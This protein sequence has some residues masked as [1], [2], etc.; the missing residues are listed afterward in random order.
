MKGF[1]QGA[2]C[3]AALLLCA[4][5]LAAQ[6]ADEGGLRLFKPPTVHVSP[7]ELDFIQRQLQSS[8]LYRDLVPR[9][10]SAADSRTTIVPQAITPESSGSDGALSVE[11]ALAAIARLRAQSSLAHLQAKVAQQN[12]AAESTTTDL[13]S[14]TV[15]AP[16]SPGFDGEAMRDLWANTEPQGPALQIIA[17][18]GDPPY[19]PVPEAQASDYAAAAELWAWAGVQG[20]AADSTAPN[21]SVSDAGALALLTLLQAGDYLAQFGEPYAANLPTNRPLAPLQHGQW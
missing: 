3:G 15:E 6:T 7:A 2:M 4:M 20:F 1:G 8:N 17:P 5:P 12:S 9:G 14:L 16:G 19:V 13:P 10:S 21:G 18:D 11:E